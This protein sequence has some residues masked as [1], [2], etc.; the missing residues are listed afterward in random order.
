MVFPKIL[1]FTLFSALNIV[2]KFNTSKIWVI[3][4]EAAIRP[5][6]YTIHI[7]HIRNEA[8]NV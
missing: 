2:L 8:I 5:T 7:L 3:F 4:F 1:E 6:I